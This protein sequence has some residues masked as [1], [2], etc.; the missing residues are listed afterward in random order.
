M[1]SIVKHGFQGVGSEWRL[2]VLPENRFLTSLS[3]EQELIVCDQDSE[4][5]NICCVTRNWEPNIEK[6]AP[7]QM[8]IRTRREDPLAKT[9]SY[10]DTNIGLCIEIT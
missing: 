7:V 10:L 2:A 6:Q 3:G 8:L 1:V 9:R 5:M 4:S